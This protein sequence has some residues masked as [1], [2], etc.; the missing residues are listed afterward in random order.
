V[1]PQLNAHPAMA[2]PGERAPSL[3][4]VVPAGDPA[5]LWRDHCAGCHGAEGRGD[6]PAAAWL[7]PRPTSL[8]DHSYSRAY[9]VQVMWNGVAGTAMPAWRDHAPADLAALADTVA[10]FSADRAAAAPDPA[11]LALGAQVYAAH[12]VQ[13]HGPGGRGDGFAAGAFKVAAVDF[14]V[15]RPTPELALKV[16]REGVAGTP[17][18]PWNDRL[19][20]DQMRAVVLYVRGFFAVGNTTRMAHAD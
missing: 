1:S 13:C 11:T 12:C 19:R 4:D 10:G 14:T 18:A 8:V 5:R 9:L 16:L 3:A 17:M 15:K 7:V 20:E 2:R 6:G